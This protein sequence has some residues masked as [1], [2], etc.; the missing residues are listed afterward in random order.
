MT[1]QEKVPGN[2]GKRSIGVLADPPKIA[3]L[4][5]ETNPR[6]LITELNKTTIRFT[7]ESLSEGLAGG[8][9]M[10][11]YGRQGTQP[12]AEW[13]RTSLP[14]DFAANPP[15]Y[16]VDVETRLLRDIPSVTGPTEYQARFEIIDALGLQDNSEPVTFFVDR[17]APYYVKNPFSRSSPPA[18]SYV[19]LDIAGGEVINDAWVAANPGG[20]VVRI[21]VNYPNRLAN[22]TVYFCLGERS[23]TTITLPVVYNGVVSGA[24]EF[25]ISVDDLKSLPNASLFQRYKLFDA[26][27]NPS[28][29][30][31][32]AG[33]AVLPIR[34]LPD[35][36]LFDPRVPATDPNN[37]VAINLGSYAIE[38]P[39][40]V[41]DYPT[42]G[43]PFDVIQ[44]TADIEVAG[45]DAL[46]PLPGP[47]EMPLNY[48]LLDTVTSGATAEAAV[49]IQYTLT[50]G[51][52]PDIPSGTTTIFVN[53]LFPGPAPDDLPILE[54]D[55]L[56]PVVVTGD[57]G[58]KDNLLPQ[59]RDKDVTFTVPAAGFPALLET[60]LVTYYWN[61]AI[62]GTSQLAD[63]D[64]ETSL[65]VG[66]SVISPAG[67]GIIPATYTIEYPGNPNVMKRLTPTAVNVQTFDINFL[68]H[69]GPFIR[70][71]NELYVSCTSMEPRTGT[72]PI[73]TVPPLKVTVPGGQTDLPTGR[74]VTIRMLAWEDK[75]K[76]RPIAGID[77][78]ETK[79][80]ANTTDPLVFDIDWALFKTVQQATPV[81]TPLTFYYVEIWYQ[82]VLGGT[83]F[84]STQVMHPVR[85]RNTSS[86]YCDGLPPTVT[87]P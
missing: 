87:R 25:T 47:F 64:T 65:K 11:V 51:P 73:Y 22:D 34:F 13:G 53:F 27:G 68:P 32:V 86:V 78:S 43:D 26:P 2:I 83:T 45:S 41:I 40:V 79:P 21:P 66:F 24:G 9:S 31:V 84:K 67:L 46:G 49:D 12:E 33:A 16:H 23:G 63:G 4:I 56:P 29:D 75:G 19:N 76:T 1:A 18:A 6:I 35:P 20:L 55:N 58:T 8:G 37:T 74:D 15:P 10:W 61:G 60:A 7:L 69:T 39:K 77:V 48:A 5:N 70:L 59:D 82:V 42:H 57:S 72:G 30:S 14:E 44:V 3:G 17:N 85:V 36:I 54:H 71:N 62:I 28:Q 80:I 50:R 81:T 52:G 38:P